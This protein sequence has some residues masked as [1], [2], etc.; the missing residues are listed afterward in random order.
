[1]VAAQVLTTEAIAMI[2]S[3][4]LF[5]SLML[6]SACTAKSSSNS[7]SGS[8]LVG[9]VS[10]EEGSKTLE[11]YDRFKRYFSE[12]MQ[13]LIELEPALNENKA[14]DRVQN[15]AWSL[16]FAPP[17]LAAIA[18]SQYQYAPLFPLIGVQNRRSMLV[19]RE[20]SPIQEISA[21]SGKTLALGNPGSATGFYFPLFNLYGL[22]LAELVL[23]ATPKAVLD[24]VIQGKADV[25]AL[26]LEEF[27]TY[28]TQVAQTKLRVLFTDS[29]Q[30]P[31]GA[32]LVSPKLDRN[33]QE[34]IRKV[35]SEAS[36]VVA[37][38]AGFITNASVPDYQYMTSVVERVR[39]IFP[40]DTKES[41]AL[42]QQKPVRLFK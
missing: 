39:S 6:L 29:H 13:A 23:S 17:G 24:A 26:S 19:V 8:L 7:G 2:V 4:R 42:L 3:R 21:I 34:R 31:S 28:K 14:L 15:R 1:M 38:E 25:G 40:G 30:V 41:V 18:I 10:Y 37:E 16:V 32:I 12:K 36:S 9:V 33:V 20:D 11:Q 35:L 22:T 27:E 5:L